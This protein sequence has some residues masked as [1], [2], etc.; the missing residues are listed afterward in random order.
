[1]PALAA[2][3]MLHLAT[4]SPIL[5]LD[6]RV[7]L[8]VL[9]ALALATHGALCS[10]A[11]QAA[12]TVAG[13]RVSW[14]SIAVLLVLLYT[15]P[16]ALLSFSLGASSPRIRVKPALLTVSVAL[17]VAAAILCSSTLSP[18]IAALAVLVL[19]FSFTE[20]SR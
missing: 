5:Y 3:A 18:A 11:L 17:A 2:V 6:V 7:S 12:F 8:V 20:A 15:P 9:V 10:G 14:A 1:M 19:S 16:L 4:P 13:A